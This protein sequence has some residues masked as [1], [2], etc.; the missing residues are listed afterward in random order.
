M[1]NGTLSKILYLG[2]FAMIG[3][4]IVA[5]TVLAMGN[6]ETP[7]Q[8]QVVMTALLA[9]IAGSHITPPNVKKTVDGLEEPHA[10]YTPRKDVQA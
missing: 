6:H 2:A 7:A 9:M 4:C 5:I 1:V 10:T 8:L 3:L